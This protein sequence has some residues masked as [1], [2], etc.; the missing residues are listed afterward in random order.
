MVGRRIVSVVNIINDLCSFLS[1]GLYS[2]WE[3]LVDSERLKTWEPET[4]RRQLLRR[5]TVPVE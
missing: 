1:S 2:G 3:R 5:L 4:E